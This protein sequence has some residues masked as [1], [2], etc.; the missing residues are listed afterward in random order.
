METPNHCQFCAQ[1]PDSA[2]HGM[3]REGLEEISQLKTCVSF[4][5]G[6][7]IMHEGA[8]PQ[9]VYCIHKGKIKLYTLGT[10]GKEQIIR[11]V[12]RGDLIGYR[13]ILSDEPISA[14]ATAL[15]DTFACYIPKS[16]FF[17]VI[18]DNPKF[19]LNLLKLSCHELGEAGKMITSLAQKNVKERLAEILLIL[20]TTFGEDEEGYIDINLTRE[21]IANMVG[22][23]TESVIRL[24]S[25]LRKEGYIRSKGKRIGLEDRSA[26]R[27]MASVF[28]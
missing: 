8:R 10:E 2:F 7:V 3:S 14:S 1:H 6:Q 26:L 17:K 15:E 28:E 11:F 22:T 19:S 12:T 5:K 18:E 25:E 24:I 23:A 9:G 16:S 13:S 27:A 4:R 20:N 21:E